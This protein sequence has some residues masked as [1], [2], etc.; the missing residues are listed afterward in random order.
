MKCFDIILINIY[1]FLKITNFDFFQTKNVDVKL[2]AFI[3][4]SG[5]QSI[6]LYNAISILY[7]FSFSKVEPQLLIYIAFILPLI[8]NYIIYYKNKRFEEVFK[9][10]LS[11]KSFL[12]YFLTLLYVVVTFYLM[13]IVSQYIRNNS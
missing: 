9:S 5:L 3:L 13:N 11:D 12:N 7:F 4:F 8:F 2:H 10:K 6:N 1:K